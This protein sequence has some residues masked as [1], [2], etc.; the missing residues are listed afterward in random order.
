MKLCLDLCQVATSADAALG[1]ASD[2]LSTAFGMTTGSDHPS[3][4]V[5]EQRLIDWECELRA[6]EEALAHR[7]RDI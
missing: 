2:N 5:V 3:R 7:E 6:R 1:K 4:G